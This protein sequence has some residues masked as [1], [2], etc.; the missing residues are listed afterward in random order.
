MEVPKDRLSTTD[1]LGD[2]VTIYPASVKGFWRNQ[3]NWSQLILLTIFLTLPWIQIG[4]EQSLLFSIPERRFVF[5]GLV[6]YAHDAPLIFFLLAIGVFGLALVTAIWGRIWCGWAC[7]Q[8]VF[9]D[10][11]FRRIETWIEGNHLQR[12]QLD[13]GALSFNKIFRKSIKWSLFLIA[14][15]II[16]HSFAAYFIGANRLAQ[17]SIHA[18]SENWVPFTIVLFFTFLV[19]FDFGWFREQFCIIMCPYGRFQSVLMDNHSL[20]VLYDEKRGEPRKGSQI[21]SEINKP[22]GDCVNCHRCV[23]VCP[24]GIDIRRGVQLECINCTACIDA[25]DEIMD[26]V[27]K[28]RGLIRY[29][30]LA[31]LD[32]KKSHL[33]N[34]RR[35]FYLVLILLATSG[36]T[37]KLSTRSSLRAEILRV[38]G[39]PYRLLEGAEKGNVMNQFKVHLQNQS[40][41]PISVNFELNPPNPDIALIEQDKSIV[42]HPGELTNHYLFIKFNKDITK[43]LGQ[44]EIVVTIIYQRVDETPSSSNTHLQKNLKL[45]GPWN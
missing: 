39:A 37:Y 20:A 17:M 33:L 7:P 4:G 2:R 28:P 34:W 29:A 24:T 8:T 30:S 41:F 3:R 11:V 26:K 16:A 12:R 10:A 31:Q 19:L 35:S 14:S 42:I 44:K 25:C 5:F 32:G 36:L 43:S 9:I 18:P 27:H 22:A 13:Q 21:K 40:Q 45:L 23:M 38:V 15:S 6:L 1:A